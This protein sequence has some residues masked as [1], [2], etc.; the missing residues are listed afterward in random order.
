MLLPFLWLSSRQCTRLKG[1]RFR[2]PELCGFPSFLCGRLRSRRTP[3]SMVTLKSTL[4]FDSRS[5]SPRLRLIVTRCEELICTTSP[6]PVACPAERNMLR[7]PC[8]YFK[9]GASSELGQRRMKASHAFRAPRRI[10]VF[11]EHA[12]TTAFLR[13]VCATTWLID[14]AAESLRYR[15]PSDIAAL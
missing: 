15:L 6:A 12:R 11:C 10:S 8:P 9:D 7:T 13:L 1:T 3:L 2:S 4:M 5:S 14:S